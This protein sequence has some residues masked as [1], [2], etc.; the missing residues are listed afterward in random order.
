MR[1]LDSSTFL[2]A[3]LK[4]T[5]QPPPQI[6]INKQKAQAIITQIQE[7]EQVT[8]TVIHLSETANIL[9]SRTT[10]GDARNIIQD[11]I[12]TSNITITPVDQHLYTA[13]IKEAEKHNIGINDALAYITMMENKIHEIYSYDK[14]F[15]NLPEITRIWR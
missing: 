9:E 11:I 14:H 6:A 12:D 3:F 10:L 5:K 7:G 1:F 2:Y 8:T 13:A 4:P 15:D